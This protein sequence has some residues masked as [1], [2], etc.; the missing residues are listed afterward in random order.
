MKVNPTPVPLTEKQRTRGAFL[1]IIH[2][3]MS[4]S[5]PRL[6]ERL[7]KEIVGIYLGSSPVVTWKDQQH[8]QAMVNRFV[9]VVLCRKFW[10]LICTQLS[11]AVR[12]PTAWEGR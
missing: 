11:A 6:S 12:V 8:A 1:W 2:A 7:A 9:L 4:R 5:G 3:S 10:S